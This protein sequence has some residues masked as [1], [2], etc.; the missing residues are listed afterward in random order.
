MKEFL[1]LRPAGLPKSFDSFVAAMDWANGLGTGAPEELRL[2]EIEGTR[3]ETT[4]LRRRIMRAPV[5]TLG[6][7]AGSTWGLPGK[8]AADLGDYKPAMVIRFEAGD[9]I[10]DTVKRL[11]PGVR[12]TWQFQGRDEVWFSDVI[13]KVVDSH[14]YEI[15]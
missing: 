14:C 15:A 9:R 4:R 10:S 12:C 3:V 7:V 8:L 2:L 6:A 13:E 1:I 11:K 5:R